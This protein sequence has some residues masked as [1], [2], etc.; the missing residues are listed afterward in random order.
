MKKIDPYEKGYIVSA[1]GAVQHGSGN[2]CN[3]PYMGY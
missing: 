1:S 3:S 2:R